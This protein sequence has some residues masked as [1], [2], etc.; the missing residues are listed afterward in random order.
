MTNAK[1]TVT[2]KTNMRDTKKLALEK[3]DAN[4]AAK[5]EAL[6]QAQA[7]TASAQS[8]L[9]SANAMPDQVPD[10]NGGMKPNE[11]KQQAVQQATEQLQQAK[12]A[13]QAAEKAKAEAKQQADAAGKDVEKSR[14]RTSRC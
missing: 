4:Y 10:G 3:A 12:E 1:N 13:E 7:N 14:K 2:A 9:D 5:S 8:A 6:S 11:A